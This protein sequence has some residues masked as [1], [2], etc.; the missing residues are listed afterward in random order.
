MI[1]S[2]AMARMPEYFASDARSASSARS[3]VMS[4]E[5][6]YSCWAAS[7]TIAAPAIS[8]AVSTS[9]LRENT[10]LQ[11]ELYVV[12][13]VRQPE[14]LLDALL[15]RVDGLRADEQLLADLRR[16]VALGHVAQYV[17]LA[18]SQLL[19]LV[20]LRGR[21]ILLGEVLG[22]HTRRRRTH[23]HVAVRDRTHRVDQLAIGRALH[24]VPTGAGLHERNQILL[25]HVHRENEHS[26]R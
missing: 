11:R 1:A 19:E 10:Q 3:C 6:M 18:L 26:R 7:R 13:P 2:A 21:R 12:R 5:R 24:E 20:A 16:R 9:R 23:V 14:L 17:A 15:V 8:H 4:R 25:F 22:Q